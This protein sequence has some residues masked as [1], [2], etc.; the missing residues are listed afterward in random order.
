MNP[1]RSTEKS[2]NNFFLQAN[3]KT[4]KSSHFCQRNTLFEAEIK[5]RIENR[6]K[7]LSSVFFNT[8]V[9]S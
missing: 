9:E 4:P 6:L 2:G 1:T 8:W 3:S 5:C 7:T